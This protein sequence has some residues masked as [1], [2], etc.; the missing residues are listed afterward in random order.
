MAT[1]SRMSRTREV[2]KVSRKSSRS[3]LGRTAMV[4][5][6]GDVAQADAGVAGQV[7]R[8][9]VGIQIAELVVAHQF[10]DQADLDAP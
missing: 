4:R 3:V 7:H 9:P 6:G 1:M 8:E 2:W 5:W 10:L